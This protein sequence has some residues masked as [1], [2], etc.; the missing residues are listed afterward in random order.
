MTH[1]V[2]GATALFVIQIPMYR[3]ETVVYPQVCVT[4]IVHNT[5]ASKYLQY[6]ENFKLG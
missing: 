6:I 5:I 2:H 1:T 3:L 4:A